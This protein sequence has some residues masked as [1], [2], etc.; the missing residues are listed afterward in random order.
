M[1]HLIIP[2]PGDAVTGM[3]AEVQAPAVPPILVFPWGN[4]SRGD[5]AIGPRIEELLGQRDLP[6]VELL[7]DF[8]LQIEHV[9]DI[10]HRVCV[11]FVDASVSATPPFEFAALQSA[12]DI[13][14][15]THAMSPQAL[16]TV[17]QR[18]SRQNPPPCYLL[19]VRG[20][21]FE[22]GR[23]LS[24]AARQHADQAVEFLVGFIDKQIAQLDTLDVK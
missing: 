5:D 19:S 13:S 8:Q 15:T 17:Y 14:Y 10:E 23:P 16:M 9:V 6:G 7:T 2:A 4:P 20:Y 22:L 18:V 12:A 11:V 3:P 1:R 24:E 21:D